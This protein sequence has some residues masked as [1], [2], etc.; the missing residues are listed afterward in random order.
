MNHLQDATSP[1]LR[2][3]LHNPVDWYPYTSEALE[4]AVN[5]DKLLIISIGYAAC[6][7]CHVME[8]ESFEDTEVAEV[9]N[10]HFVSIKVDREERPDVDKV[11]MDA[12]LIM[13]Q[14]GG[15][16]LNCICL[17]DGRPIFGGTYFPKAQWMQILTQLANLYA[18]KPEK[19]REYGDKM[20][21]ALKEIGKIDKSENNA[22]ITMADI[23][24]IFQHWLPEMDTQ[25]GGF[26]GNQNK[27]PLPTNWQFMLQAFHA[28][29]GENDKLAQ[30]IYQPL[31]LTLTR[32]AQGGIFDHIGG[33]FSRYATDPQWH[34]PHFEKMLYDNAQLVSLYAEAH[35]LS[36]NPQY[37]SVVYE[38]LAFVDAALTSPEYGFYTALDA[39]SEGEE[40]KFYVWEYDEVQALA[41][42]IAPAFA[43]AFLNYYQITPK[44]NWEEGKNVCMALS[45]LAYFCEKQT[46]D[47]AECETAFAHIRQA[48]YKRRALR[49]SPGLDDKI[50]TSWNAW[51]LKGYVDAYH[52][53]GE[54]Q[55]LQTAE[56]NAAFIWEKLSTTSDIE[57]ARALYRNYK[58]GAASIPAFLDDYA[59]VITAYLALYEVNFQSIWVK[60]AEALMQHVI[61][62]FYDAATGMFFYTSDTSPDII[63]RKYET[64][65]DV[66]PAA[67]SVLGHALLTLY[68]ITGNRAYQQYALQMLNNMR[69]Q[70]LHQPRWHANW[71][72]LALRVAYTQ[73]EVVIMGD[74][75][76]QLRRE[77]AAYYTPNVRFAGSVD[78][79]DLPI[80]EN[81]L[82]PNETLIYIC[83]QQ[84]C[85]LPVKTVQAAFH[86]M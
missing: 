44:G 72:R 46:L 54:T 76:L 1:Y 75:A 61:A 5:E 9:M 63:V 83:T 47:P 17:P 35:Q 24:H 59:A 60:R 41:A 85:G 67:C 57:N 79:M 3:H 62:H 77:F 33:G 45:P 58:E 18:T 70:I 52:V 10:Q 6:H 42:H 80:L 22:A 66:I 68:P 20:E 28:F 26:A 31:Q 50:L 34:V 36:P 74:N 29:L 69:E 64:S 71:A 56:K 30:Q 55:W 53:L 2:Q 12:L 32:I 73:H 38:T 65:D 23:A 40:G 37:K 84:T 27:F 16:P 25:W 13:T 51:M 39:D 4:K 8:K 43:E 82:Q 86:Q 19:A 7:W 21:N 78:S 81:R 15:W 14:Q 48:L 49:V 11:Y